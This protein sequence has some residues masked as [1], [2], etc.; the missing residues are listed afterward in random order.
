MLEYVL[1]LAGL[2]LIAGIFWY[3]AHAV[4]QHAERTENLVTA[5]SP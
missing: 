5:D 1:C 4:L 3:L 2:V